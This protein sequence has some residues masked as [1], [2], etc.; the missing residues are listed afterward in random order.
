VEP[1]TDRRVD[2]GRLP[3]HQPEGASPRLRHEPG[4]SARRLIRPLAAQV[5][6]RDVL[7]LSAGLGLSFALPA[8]DLVAAERRGPERQKSLITLW[9]AGG[10]SQLDTWDPHPKSR[11]GGPVRAIETSTKGLRIAHLLPQVAE[12]M[13]HLSIIRSLVSKEGDHQRGT[14]F[15]QTGYRPDPTVIHP[16]LGA[17]LA[18]SLPDEAVHIPQ[19]V[20]LAT[21]DN[22]EAPRGGYLGAEF[23]AFRVFDPGRNLQNM[24]PRVSESRQDRRL[25]NLAV[26]SK[27]FEQGRSLQAQDTLHQHV[28]DRALAMMES[29]QLKAFQLDE[30]PAETVKRYGDSR[31]GRGCLVARRLVERG[32]RSVQVTLRGFD[33]HANNFEGHQQQA[34]QLDPAFAALIDDLASSKLLDSTVVLCIGEFGRTPALNGLDGRDHWPNGFSCVVGG[35]GLRS[36]VLI[37]GTDPD[38]QVRDK[39]VPPHDPVAVPDLYATILKTI[40]V[41]W[42]EEVLTPIGRPMMLS[43]G[44]PIERL[45]G[46]AG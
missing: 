5:T 1:L 43:Q 3:P 45:L 26:V 25:E 7:R 18:H 17:I 2:L 24:R 35:G 37:G 23:D 12:R 30:E 31:F 41:D 39:T 20:A 13:R 33:T 46:G 4:A 15:V 9:M 42:T 36:G 34:A 11:H 44:T 28:V 21:G 22:F 14:Y 40:G 16:S 19:Y 29:P 6:R 38:A 10:P 27:S 32:V 8:I